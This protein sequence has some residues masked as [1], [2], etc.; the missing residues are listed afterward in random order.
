MNGFKRPIRFQRPLCDEDVGP[1]QQNLYDMTIAH[2]PSFRKNKKFTI[3]GIV[4]EQVALQ[5]ISSSK[6]EREV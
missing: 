2:N 4:P 1:Q 5:G 6:R 3:V